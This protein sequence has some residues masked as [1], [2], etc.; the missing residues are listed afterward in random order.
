MTRDG[1][2]ASHLSGTR[3]GDGCVQFMCVELV[4]DGA[5]H[6]GVRGQTW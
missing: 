5:S 3:L 1:D 4:S 2:G 6:F